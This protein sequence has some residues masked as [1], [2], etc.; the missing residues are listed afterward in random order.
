MSTRISV[1][2]RLAPAVLAL[3]TASLRAQ[4]APASDALAK[5]VPEGTVIFVQTPSL[6]RLGEAAAKLAKFFG[7]E[8]GQ[9]PNVDDLLRDI[10][11]PGSAKEIDHQRPIAFC[12]VLPA[13]PGAQPIPAFLVPATSPEAFV[14]SLSDSHAKVN[15]AIEGGYVCVSKS[16]GAQPGPKHG[17]RPAPIAL[18]L[19]AGEIVARID[20]KRIVD[21]YRPMIEMG[22][23]QLEMTM[24]SAP[25]KATA[26]VDIQPL[27]KMY[28][29]GVRS[30]IDS[31]QGLDFAVRLEGDR[32]EVASEMTMIE[33]SALAEFGSRQKTDVR[34]L[35]RFADPEASITM[36]AG[37]DQAAMLKHF[38]P[39]IDALVE[40]YPASLRPGFQKMLGS[41]DELA[42][43]IGPAMCVNGDFDTAG[44][45]VVSYLHPRDPAKLVAVY[46][47][48]MGAMPCAT[49]DEPKE[50][51]LDG[52]RVTRTRLHVDTKALLENQKQALPELQGMLDKMYGKDGLA[53][54]FATKG[55]V[56]V[57]V[58]GGDE[59]FLRTA[60][61]KISRAGKP[62][63]NILRAIEP[64]GD[65]NPCIALQYNLGK[66]MQGFQGLM[67][68]EARN[69]PVMPS[70]VSTAITYA[71]G[72][73]GRV[74]RS[75]MSMDLAE[76][77]AAVRAMKR[78]ATGQS[79][80]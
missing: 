10:D 51:D 13:Q 20:V 67:G 25:P 68:E 3:G 14:R 48:M 38:R 55:D 63:P 78:P 11:V 32:L 28:M 57:I 43:E 54:T 42:A 17:E 16:L 50:D 44:M 40:V 46:R 29:E 74:W 73:D 1:L 24:A 76:L 77:G 80:K 70:G 47:K 60:V 26:G 21:H 30:V 61:G 2:C 58:L 53:L 72:I 66:V 5:L 12:L 19:P 49:L 39:I 62:M 8:G 36:L 4:T 23:G 75:V 34:S 64:F 35:A 15:T 52:V 27:M 65:L 7:P 71:G 18:G 22:L 37:V 33:K 59:G 79:Q 69:L 31:G 9:T 56:T 45:R 6:D 41:A